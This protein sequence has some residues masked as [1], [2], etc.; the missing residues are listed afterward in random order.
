MAGLPTWL[1]LSGVGAILVISFVMVERGRRVLPRNASGWRWNIL[2]IGPLAWLA[3]QRSVKPAL[4]G[5]VF[6]VF[7]FLVYAGFAGDPVVNITPV[8]TWTIWWAGLIFLVLFFGKAW[9]FVCPWD[10]AAT[11]VQALPKLWGSKRPLSLGWRWPHALRNIYLAIGLF[12]LLTWFEL[13]YQV[14]TSPVGTAVLAL[15]MVGLAVTPAMLF[16]RRSFCRYGCMIG[17]ISGL[18]AMFAPIEVRARDLDLCRRCRT[19]ECFSGSDNVPGC[20]TFQFLPRMRANTYCTQ[21][22]F[23]A[24]SC[25]HRNVA[26]NLRP[27]AADLAFASRPKIDESFLAIILLA[28]TSFHGLT[29]TPFWDSESGWSM[30][31]WLRQSLGVGQLAAFTLG[32]VGILAILVTAFWLLCAVAIQAAPDEAVTQKKAFLYFAYSLLPVALF[33][34]LAHNSMHFFM[35][36]QWI[37]PLISD[38]LG[39]GWNLFGTVALRPGPLLSNPSIWL[40][41]A[42]FVVVGHI[43]GIMIAHRAA[44]QLYPDARQATRALIPMLAG[45]ILYSW[46]SL[47][48]LHLDMNMRTSLM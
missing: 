44:R 19:R 15:V 26:V 1:F 23:C 42:G 33:Y 9:C 8:T 5:S 22:G 16:D 4:Q 46:L 18:Y 35:E 34:H 28:L 48:I 29:M 37:V 30:I 31:G 10:Q 47:W 17:R 27:F 14:T 6:I 7:C 43:F 2:T 40:L 38:P 32:M 20:P 3:R 11:L 25:R 24:R 41:Q 36:A 21:C 39:R 45:M 12:I 13:G